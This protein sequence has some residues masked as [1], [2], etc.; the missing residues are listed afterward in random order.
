MLRAATRS[1]RRR[2]DPDSTCLLRRWSVLVDEL[3]VHHG[4]P[5]FVQSGLELVGCGTGVAHGPPGRVQ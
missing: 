1:A 3:E 5:G 4:L 2:V